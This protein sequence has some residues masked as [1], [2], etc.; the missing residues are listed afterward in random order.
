[1]IAKNFFEISFA[2]VFCSRAQPRVFDYVEHIFAKVTDINFF[3]VDDD[4]LILNSA[5]Y[6]I[7][8]R[9]AV[10][11]IASISHVKVTILECPGFSNEHLRSHLVYLFK[12]LDTYR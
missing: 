9:Y 2:E 6:V 5:A 4:V 12:R 8:H 3:V 1:L 7:K 10:L 11:L